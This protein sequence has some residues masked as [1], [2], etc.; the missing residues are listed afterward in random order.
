M[1]N[2]NSPSLEIGEGNGAVVPWCNFVAVGFEPCRE[3][4]DEFKALIL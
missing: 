1:H 4:I 2:V 3:R